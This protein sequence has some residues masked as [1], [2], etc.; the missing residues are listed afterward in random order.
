MLL[1]NAAAGGKVCRHKVKFHPRDGIDFH[2][3]QIGPE[4]A[5]LGKTPSAAHQLP[6]PEG[7]AALAVD[8]HVLQRQTVV[9]F[10]AFF[11]IEADGKA[12]ALV[13]LAARGDLFKKS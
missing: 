13:G 9:V 1:Q 3:F 2:A 4:P 12:A 10:R 5:D 11:Q 8:L 6:G 7:I